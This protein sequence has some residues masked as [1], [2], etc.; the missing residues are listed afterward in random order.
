MA[1]ALFDAGSLVFAPKPRQYAHLLANACLADSAKLSITV[2]GAR[3]EYGR[4]LDRPLF[5][6]SLHD[7]SG[8]RLEA[9]QDS[10]PGQ[11]NARTHTIS[12]GHALQFKTPMRQI[13]PGETGPGCPAI[14]K[15][16][17]ARRHVI[18]TDMPSKHISLLI[19]LALPFM[20]HL[21]CCKSS[22]LHV[23]PCCKS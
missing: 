5:S 23:A 22:T 20:L 19:I 9:A 2:D 12:A 6:V 18:K 13:P 10:P 11:Y 15:S 16:M 14:K 4:S 17:L 7:A 21:L 3:V 1:A 8:K